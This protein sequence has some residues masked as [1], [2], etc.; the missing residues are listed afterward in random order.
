MSKIK[1]C[2]ITNFDDAL[3][4]A[5]LG[6]NFIGLSFIKQSQKKVSEKTAADIVSK[7]PPF[8]SAAGV[9]ENEEKANI[10]K[11]VKKIALKAVQF[12]G[13]ETPEI[14]E[15]Y[16]NAGLKVFK[17]QKLQTDD[18][19]SQI[20][21]FIGKAD[22]FIVDIT[23]RAEDGTIT[24]NLEIAQKAINLGISCFISGAIGIENIKEALNKVNPFGFDFDSE[25]E[26]LPKRKD[27]DKM[28]KAV[29]LASGLKI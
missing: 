2:G 12:N 16:K 25:I 28:S 7:L 1:I 23:L 10:D 22:Y 13:S 8:V 6:A 19:L 20:E 27:Y 5:N 4:A 3:N 14:C 15:N 24:N 11:I 17:F 21:T 18:D 9:F 26:R 29:K